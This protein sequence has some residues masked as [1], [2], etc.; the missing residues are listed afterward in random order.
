MSPTVFLTQTE[1]VVPLSLLKISPIPNRMHFCSPLASTPWYLHQT[2]S[3]LTAP[4]GTTTIGSGSCL[5][6]LTLFH[7][8]GLLDLLRCVSNS[9]GTAAA[10]K[11]HIHIQ[12]WHSAQIHHYSSLRKVRRSPSSDGISLYHI[13]G[14]SNCWSS[15]VFEV[16]LHCY[17]MD[18][19]SN[20]WM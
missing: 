4:K 5:L 13:T 18:A 10:A 3:M 8:V 1:W 17:E 11:V 9:T 14:N 19:N 12:R 7:I 2:L 6:M 20:S 15:C 16:R